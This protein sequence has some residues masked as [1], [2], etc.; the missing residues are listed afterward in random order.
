MQL[1]HRILIYLDFVHV[2]LGTPS[3]V[4]QATRVVVEKREIGKLVQDLSKRSSL[5][6]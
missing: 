1:M 6:L 5:Q 4:A 3:S 2:P